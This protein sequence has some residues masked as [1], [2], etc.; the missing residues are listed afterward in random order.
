MSRVRSVGAVGD[1]TGTVTSDNE[2]E[3]DEAATAGEVVEDTWE[4]SLAAWCRAARRRFF[5]CSE[6]PRW[7][8]W[9]GGG[10]GGGVGKKEGGKE[11]GAPG[12]PRVQFS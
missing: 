8:G 1:V 10:A 12:W 11:W 5:S 3:A 2:D 7:R 9:R 4:V 6:G